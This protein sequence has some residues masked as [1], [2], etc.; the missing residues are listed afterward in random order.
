MSPVTPLSGSITMLKGPNNI[1]GT[2]T[3]PQRARALVTLRKVHNL[4]ES[5]A[6]PFVPPMMEYSRGGQEGQPPLLE[7]L[8]GA[9]TIFLPLHLA[10][11]ARRQLANWSLQIENWMLFTGFL[12]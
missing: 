12:T 8:G 2:A 6:P 7:N 10:D 5:V 9:K 4:S 1:K 11:L 3:P